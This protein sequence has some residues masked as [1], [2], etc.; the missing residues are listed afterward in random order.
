MHTTMYPFYYTS[1]IYNKKN[2]IINYF[3]IL[4]ILFLSI[5]DVSK[6]NSL[7]ILNLDGENVAADM[8]KTETYNHNKLLR[9]LDYQQRINSKVPVTTDT[10]TQEEK[11]EHDG[12][13]KSTA[14]GYEAH[15][16]FFSAMFFTRSPLAG[17][18]MYGVHL[19]FIT[20]PGA[21]LAIGATFWVIRWIV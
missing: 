21:V 4:I 11:N 18:T 19:F 14:E 15:V 20:L 13:G 6:V 12:V 9:V 17:D 3:F 5:N 10:E 8:M 2:I 16:D 1:T 7:E